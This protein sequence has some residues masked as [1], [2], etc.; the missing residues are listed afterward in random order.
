MD[1]HDGDEETSESYLPGL[2]ITRLYGL[3][4]QL[5]L[6]ENGDLPRRDWNQLP[7]KAM[8]D[9]AGETQNFQHGN[10]PVFASSNE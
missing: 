3:I 5:I 4:I 10:G 2:T 7:A 1:R 9:G 6:Q 8:G